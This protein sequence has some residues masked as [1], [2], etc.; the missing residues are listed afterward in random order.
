MNWTAVS[1]LSVP[2]EPH[3]VWEGIS[4]GRGEDSLAFW[5]QVA[6]S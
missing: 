6:D 3:L 2:L 5:M 4:A 1:S